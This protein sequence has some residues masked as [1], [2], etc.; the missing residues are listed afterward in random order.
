MAG[1][2]PGVVGFSTTSFPLPKAELKMC[3]EY[4]LSRAISNSEDMP[5]T[6]KAW[7]LTVFS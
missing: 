6:G 5:G 4:L 2:G 3:S 7:C 1:L